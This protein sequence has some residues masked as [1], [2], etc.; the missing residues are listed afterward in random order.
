[1][2]FPQISQTLANVGIKEPIIAHAELEAIALFS[3]AFI[4]L[5]QLYLNMQRTRSFLHNFCG[6]ILFVLALQG[7]QYES[8]DALFGPGCP[9]RIASYDAFV[10]TIITSRCSGCHSGS[11]PEGGLMLTA[12]QE[13]KTAALNGQLL[14]RIELPPSN[15]ASMP[16]NGSLDTCDVQLIR[17][18]IDSGAPEF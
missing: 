11:N 7:C 12:Y 3:L 1:M 8:E 16:P 13:V 14:E 2:T 15:S 10:E 18:W 4:Q 17:S 9:D 5:A 6:I